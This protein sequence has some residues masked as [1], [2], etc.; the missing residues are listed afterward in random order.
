MNR[1]IPARPSLR[2]PHVDGEK[3]DHSGSELALIVMLGEVPDGHVAEMRNGVLYVDADA[4]SEHIAWAVSEA[5]VL[6]ITGEVPAHMRRL[7]LV[8]GTR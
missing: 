2:D 5:A 8:G 7:R 1:T 6:R 3:I 4:P